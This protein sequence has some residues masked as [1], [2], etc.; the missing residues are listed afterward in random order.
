[1]LLGGVFCG[2]EASGANA[3]NLGNLVRGVA[4]ERIKTGEDD[5]ESKSRNRCQAWDC[6]V[7]TAMTLAEPCYRKTLGAV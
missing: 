6:P 4:R 7:R 5:D 1:M 3:G 2:E